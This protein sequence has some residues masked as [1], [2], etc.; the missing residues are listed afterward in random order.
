VKLIWD[1]GRLAFM[2]MVSGELAREASGGILDGGKLLPRGF[3]PCPTVVIL[4]I[5]TA[6]GPRCLPDGSHR[7]WVLSGSHNGIL[8]FHANES[9]R[10]PRTVTL[11]S[12]RHR[13]S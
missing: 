13:V 9:Q 4:R 6:A 2:F 1:K 5:I 3:S 10:R 12:L 7:M 8:S 11:F